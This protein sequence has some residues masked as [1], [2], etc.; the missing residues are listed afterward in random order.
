MRTD[1]L[2]HQRIK[3]RDQ[4]ASRL[5]V[6]L[7]RSLNQRAC[8]R[9]IHAI[10]RASTPLPMTGHRALRLQVLRLDRPNKNVTGD[11]LLRSLGKEA[12]KALSKITN[13][14]NL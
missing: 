6:I 2:R 3:L 9:I 13:W 11:I 12:Q 8:F 10:E 4:C 5:I 14:N 7:E 1:H